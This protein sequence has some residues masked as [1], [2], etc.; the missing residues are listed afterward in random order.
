M[1]MDWGTE[2]NSLSNKAEKNLN[3]TLVVLLWS[4]PALPPPSTFGLWGSPNYST[5][6]QIKTGGGR[7]FRRRH[8]T[9]SFR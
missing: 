9:V 4:L 1:D 5:G 2:W 8:G 7:P 6:K 3:G